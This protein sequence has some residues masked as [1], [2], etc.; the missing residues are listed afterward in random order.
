MPVCYGRPNMLFLF[1]EMVF[2]DIH[3]QGMSYSQGFSVT[4][5][6]IDLH[7]YN[8]YI[9][10]ISHILENQL[11]KHFC[12]HNMLFPNHLLFLCVGFSCGS[13]LKNQKAKVVSD[14]QITHRIF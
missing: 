3:S 8:I 10:F 1:T 5:K 14:I 6:A 12:A 2:C 4:Q 11:E 13:A 9:L 7:H